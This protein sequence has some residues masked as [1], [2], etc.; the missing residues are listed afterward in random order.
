MR[1]KKGDEDAAFVIISQSVVQTL[2]GGKRS[3]CIY[4]DTSIAL[5]FSPGDTLLFQPCMRD[6]TIIKKV[7][8][9]LSSF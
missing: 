8:R 9:V 1:N 6:F 7:K 2:D 3:R 4:P 5:K